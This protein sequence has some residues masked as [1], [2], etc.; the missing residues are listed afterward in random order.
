M[1][2]TNNKMQENKIPE[3]FKLISY[4]LPETCQGQAFSEALQTPFLQFLAF[5]IAEPLP[6]CKIR[7]YLFSRAQAELWCFADGGNCLWVLL[8]KPS[9][10]SSGM[11]AEIC[12]SLAWRVCLEAA[13]HPR[14]VAGLGA[15]LL[16]QP[17]V[18]EDAE[19]EL[20]EAVVLLRMAPLVLTAW[21]PSFKVTHSCKDEEENWPEVPKG[22]VFPQGG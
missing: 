6:G 19:Q 11:G 15:E 20:L 7:R 4:N 5:Q 21:N 16:A 18:Q 9:R 17:G 8:Q 14:A 13:A 10:S 22:P 12:H 3:L 2:P 1:M